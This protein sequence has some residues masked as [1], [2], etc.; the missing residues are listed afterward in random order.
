MNTCSEPFFFAFF[1]NVLRE[2]GHIAPE[3]TRTQIR[4]YIM[5]LKRNTTLFNNLVLLD[6]DIIIKMSMTYPLILKECLE[7]GLG[8]AS[9]TVDLI[10]WALF[11]GPSTLCSF[12]PMTPEL[13]IQA[14]HHILD[15]KHH[16]LFLSYD[17]ELLN[18]LQ[19][20][21]TNQALIRKFIDNC[22]EF[23][24]TNKWL[25]SYLHRGNS[26]NIPYIVSHKYHRRILYQEPKFITTTLPFLRQQLDEDESFLGPEEERNQYYHRLVYI[27]NLIE[28]SRPIIKK[29]N[30]NLLFWTAILVIRVRNFINRYYEPPHGKG[31]LKQK[32]KWEEHKQL[33]NIL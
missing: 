22:P 24:I 21:P 29:E 26:K 12:T 23:Q 20:F 3:Y 14:L 4:E 32:T 16:L 10:N 13:R 25:L 5:D 31:F 33:Y 9:N 8:T 19:Y 6:G 18:I 7:Q 2:Y 17:Y 28:E 27:Q 15:N 1:Y 30:W 11:S